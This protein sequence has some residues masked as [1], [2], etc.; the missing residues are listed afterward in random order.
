MYLPSEP[1]QLA[2]GDAHVD[3][4][5]AAINRLA[6][7]VMAFVEDVQ[8]L[9]RSRQDHATPA[10]VLARHGEV[11]QHQVLVRHDDFRIV[12]RAACGEK[13]AD[14]ELAALAPGTA[15]GAGGHH[16]TQQVAYGFRRAVHVAVPLAVVKGSAQLG[17]RLFVARLRRL[18][19]QGQIRIET[20]QT[21]LPGI[22]QAV[23]RHA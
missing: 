1:A 7:H 18:Q 2:H 22:I 12:H 11:G 23:R 15:A 13:R 4:G 5:G 14:H 20:G 16:R 10:F 21:H 8:G 3:L 19:P 9:V 6:R 17:Q